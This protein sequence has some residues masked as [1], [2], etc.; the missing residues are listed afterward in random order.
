MNWNKMGILYQDHLLF[1]RDQNQRIS[2]KWIKK[3]RSKFKYGDNNY[4][5][6]RFGNI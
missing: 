1:Y 6:K 2:Y 4:K 5:K 3:L